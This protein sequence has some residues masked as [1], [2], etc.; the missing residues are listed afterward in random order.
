MVIDYGTTARDIIDHFTSDQD[1]NSIVISK[2][3][4][5]DMAQAIADYASFQTGLEMAGEDL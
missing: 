1:P 2:A 4:L 3:S 5:E